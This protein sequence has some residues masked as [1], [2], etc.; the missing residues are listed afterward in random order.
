MI[1]QKF[2]AL[3]MPLKL[4]SEVKQEYQSMKE[5]SSGHE[6]ALNFE[7][8]LREGLNPGAS[9]PWL[10]NNHNNVEVDDKSTGDTSTFYQKSDAVNPSSL[11][12]LVNPEFYKQDHWVEELCD[13]LFKLKRRGATIKAE[14][15]YGMIHFISCLYVLAVVPQQLQ[16]AGYNGRN[17]VVAVALCSGIATI[18]C[19]L[20]ANLPFVLAPPTVVSIFLSVFLQQGGL[21]PNHGNIAVILSGG[22]LIL[23][24]WKPLGRLA[25][26][27]IP[28]SIQVGTAI[29]I[30]LLTAL[31]GAT[32][33][34]FVTTGKYSIVQMGYITPKIMIAICGV[35]IIA[36]A[37]F[38][39]VKGSFALAVVFCSIVWWIYDDDFPDTFAGA[40]SLSIANLARG[41]SQSTGLLVSDLIF[42]YV[43]Y[44]NGLMTSLSNLAVLTRE[45]STV[46]RG[47]WI[48][49]MCGIFTMI[50]GVFCSA[51]I[52][53]SPESSASIKAGAKTGLS[54][55]VCG[56]LFLLSLF[57][58]PLFEETPAAGTSPVLIMIGIILFQNCSRIDWRNITAAAPA[59]VVLF[60][61]P[62]TYSVIQGMHIPYSLTA[63]KLKSLL[64]FRCDR[65]VWSLS[66]CQSSH[67]RTSRTCCRL[68][69]HL[70]SSHGRVVNN[71]V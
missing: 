44:L 6:N 57:F 19:G 25:A 15:Y 22:L 4:N 18:F 38:Y 40:P 28:V 37:M 45:D 36:V 26:R 49:I 17:T 9:P 52:L 61:I 53:I 58:A 54:A 33:I 14:I 62:F 50:S 31:A 8:N 2:T 7:S 1:N 23:F 32:E 67:W 66:L 24:G 21:D 55:V 60:F 35:I 68:H 3:L 11:H 63:F 59:F 13:V 39:H 51:P 47:R 46:P 69:H 56:V 20:F 27:L 43:L 42:L 30:G 16:S 71:S 70:L 29:G 5:T 65:R 12:A 41:N 10:A 48:F 64:L 34:D